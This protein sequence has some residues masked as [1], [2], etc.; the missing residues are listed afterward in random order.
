MVD[1]M[2]HFPRVGRV[3]WIG[4]RSKRRGTVLELPEVRALVGAGL[5]G[6]HYGSAGGSR[7][8]T[9][10]Q[11]EHLAVIGSLLGEPP[12]EPARLRRNLAISGINLTALKGRCF[13]VGEVLLEGSGLCHPCARMEEAL[14]PGGYNA[15]R[16]HGGL[17]ARVLQGGLI[18]LGDALRA[19]AATVD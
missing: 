5:H 7:G 13:T 19:V 11:Y 14:G 4:V 9:L 16:G 15:M 10:I 18:R 6:D 17:N 3:V 2:E 8:I 12:L 1:L